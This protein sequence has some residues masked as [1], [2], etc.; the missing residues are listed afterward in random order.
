MFVINHLHIRQTFLKY[1]CLLNLAHMRMQRSQVNLTVNILGILFC[2]LI[3][4]QIQHLNPLSRRQDNLITPIY[5]WE[6]LEIRRR[7]N[8]I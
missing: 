3:I 8:P 6:H 1:T 4:I 5:R 7:Y 2:L